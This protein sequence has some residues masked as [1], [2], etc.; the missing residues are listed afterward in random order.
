MHLYGISCGRK[1]PSEIHSL[2]SPINQPCS[3]L[4]LSFLISNVKETQQPGEDKGSK[5]FKH[6]V[7][8]F[9]IHHLKD[10]ET[11]ALIRDRKIGKK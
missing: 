1:K 2:F 6:L 8:P 3:Q 7:E 10:Y 5:K 4:T 9:L 11:T